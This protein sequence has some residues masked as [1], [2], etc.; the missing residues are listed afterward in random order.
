MNLIIGKGQ[1]GTS[2]LSLIPDAHWYDVKDKAGSTYN[3]ALKYDTIWFAIRHTNFE[4]W[5]DTIIPY[6]YNIRPKHAVILSTCPPGSM[7][8]LNNLRSKPVETT[9]IHWAPRGKHPDLTSALRTFRPILGIPKTGCPTELYLQFQKMCTD[10]PAPPALV[11]YRESELGKLTSL[12]RYFIDIVFCRQMKDICDAQPEPVQFENVY[13]LPTEV[14][15]EGFD[16]DGD[17]TYHRPNLKPL[18][19][20]IGGHCVVPGFNMFLNHVFDLED[21]DL[22]NFYH[23]T[24]W[25]DDLYYGVGELGWR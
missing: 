2:L 9:L 16:V 8:D 3:P 4:A 13:T 23:I 17:T 6:L 5:A 14:Y 11:S 21:D 25:L 19:G 7:D 15:N 10:I 18:K 12:A 1:I 24:S 22:P 20:K